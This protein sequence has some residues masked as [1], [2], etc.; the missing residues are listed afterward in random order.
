MPSVTVGRSGGGADGSFRGGT[1]PTLT[2]SQALATTPNQG[3]RSSSQA[4]PTYAPAGFAMPQTALLRQSP[5]IRG[6]PQ[7]PLSEQ[8]PF[9]QRSPQAGISPSLVASAGASAAAVPGPPQAA[10][11]EDESATSSS[12]GSAGSSG[13]RGSRKARTMCPED[14]LCTLINDLN[15]QRQFFHTCRLFPCYHGHVKRHAKFFRH[16]EGQL[17]VTNTSHGTS[18]EKLRALTSVNFTGISR[19]TPGATPFT[20]ITKDM[21]YEIHGDWHKV[22]LHTLK[23]YLCQVIG[24]QPSM[25][26]LFLPDGTPLDDDLEFVANAVPSSVMRVEVAEGAGID[27]ELGGHAVPPAMPPPAAAP[28]VNRSAKRGTA[29]VPLAEL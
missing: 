14:E 2:G 22:K 4:G 28:A 15:H 3:F 21:A 26:E 25:Q 9:A 23:R 7:A 19:D 13:R 20:V 11:D 24:V 8:L 29:P 16:K 17:L 6:S 12:I 18:S 10:D 5:A 1:T 27:V